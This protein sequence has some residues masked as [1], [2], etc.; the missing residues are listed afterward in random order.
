MTVFQLLIEVLSD[1]AE[2]KITDMLTVP[3]LRLNEV[4]EDGC[5]GD[6][7]LGKRHTT[8]FPMGNQARDASWGASLSG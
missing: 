5:D 3:G 6:V 1:E 8:S 4:C 2:M 7:V